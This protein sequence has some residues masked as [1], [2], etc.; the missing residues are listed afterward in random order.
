MSFGGGGGGSLFFGGGERLGEEGFFLS[1][2]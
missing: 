2:E 1:Q